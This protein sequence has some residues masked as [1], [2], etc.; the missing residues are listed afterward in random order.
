VTVLEVI[1]RSTDFLSKKG[2]ESPRLQIELLLAHALA[3]PRLNLYLDFTRT[4]SEAELKAVRE[5]VKRRGNREPLQHIIGSTSFCGL[6]IKVTPEVLIPRPETELLAENA[7]EFLDHLGSPERGPVSFLDLGTGTGCLAVTIAV[8][9]PRARGHAVDIS[10][11]ALA[12]ARENAERH[13]VSNRI[14]FCPSDR[15]SAVPPGLRVSLIASNPP[16]IP[17][18]EI[19]ALSPEVRDHDP[20]EALDGGPDGLTFYRHLAEEA[21]PFLESGGKLM[22][23]FGDGQADKIHSILAAQGWVIQEVKPDY[24]G[25]PR[26]LI[27]QPGES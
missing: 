6:E 9:C 20:R 23:E 21:G 24:T 22:M 17:T 4:L 27:A 11:E 15:F 1:Q 13:G 3:I 5:M 19:A 8:K 14:Q 10:A 25:R 12:V 16:Y 26:I 2:V 7:Y 18:G